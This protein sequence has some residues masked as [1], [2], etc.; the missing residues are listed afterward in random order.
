VAGCIAICEDPIVKL[1]SLAASA[2]AEYPSVRL[3]LAPIATLVS[4]KQPLKAELPIL[5][6]E[7]P[8]DTDAKLEQSS[9]A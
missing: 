9:K 8:I 2:N 1:T 4:L 7:L 5:V 3:T 6:T